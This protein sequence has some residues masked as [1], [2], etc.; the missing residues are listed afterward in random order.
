[1]DTHAHICMRCARFPARFSNIPDARDR[2]QTHGAY[3]RSV[4]ALRPR[5]RMAMV[6][7]RS[8][9]LSASSRVCSDDG[10]DSV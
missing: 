6:W 8:G 2:L 3:Q 4:L 10:S 1:M 9:K 5:V 7:P